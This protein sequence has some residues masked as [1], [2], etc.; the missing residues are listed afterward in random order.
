LNMSAPSVT[1]AVAA[2]EE[3]IGARLFVRTT[4]S[5]KLT[6]AGTRYFDDCRQ[7]LA[8]IAEA[9]S[10]AAGAHAVPSGTLTVTAPVLFGKIYI[11]PIL[12]EYLDLHPNVVA[13]TIFVDRLVN[14]VDEGIDVAIRIGHLPDSNLS[15]IRVG[16]VRRVLCGSP[17][18]LEK[19][20]IPRNPSELVNHRIIAATSAWTSL[21][22]KF[23]VDEKISVVVRPQLYCDTYQGLISSATQGWGLARALSYQI[24]PELMNGSLQV[25]LPEFEPE[26]IP[27]HVI[28]AEGRRASAKVRSFVDFVVDRLRTNA[29]VN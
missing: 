16:S 27:V 25:V 11:L 20:G 9:E 5:V 29:P 14:V 26:P 4:R 22:W 17:A 2:L 23:G 15:A 18:Y 1:R 21:E 12:T 10:A 3:S 24:L 8:D 13:R 28:H 19:N 6:D 7:I